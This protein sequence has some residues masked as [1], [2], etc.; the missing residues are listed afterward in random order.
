MTQI[1]AMVG[2]NNKDSVNKK[3]VNYVAEFFENSEIKIQNWEFF[4]APV[5]SYQLEKE[6]GIPVDI[7]MLKNTLDE[8]GA[9]ILAVTE[10]NLTVSSFLK[11]IIDWLSRTD[12]Q[13]LKGKKILL[14]STSEDESGSM[15]ALAY[16]KNVLP[17][18][19]AEV[20]ESFSLPKFSQNYDEEANTLKDEVML[21]GL[22]GVVSNFRGAIDDL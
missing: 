20:V 17:T 7:Q 19:G 22:M 14:M 5:Y 13:F 6:R 15:N 10:H 16:M 3:L 2:S 21:L 11:N 18:F 12:E 8:H 9:I 1:L 4:D